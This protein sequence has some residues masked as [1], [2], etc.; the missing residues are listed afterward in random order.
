M[1][2]VCQTPQTGDLGKSAIKMSV[3]REG[4]PV[5]SGR[6][7]VRGPDRQKTRKVGTTIS[8]VMQLF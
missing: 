5:R 2:R 8:A 3:L 7:G 6:E 4:A 1:L